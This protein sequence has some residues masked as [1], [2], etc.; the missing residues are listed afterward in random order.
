MKIYFYPS[1]NTKVQRNP[2]VSEFIGNLSNHCTVVNNKDVSGAAIFD[3]CK[4]IFSA[5]IFIYNWIE[6]IGFKR[7]GTLQALFFFCCFFIAKLRRC[8]IVWVFHNITPHEGG[9]HKLSEA[10]RVIMLKHSS[11]IVTHSKD[12]VAYLKRQ[13]SVPVYFSHHPV[14]NTLKL[15]VDIVPFLKQYDILIW[16]RI[17]RYKGIKEFL[18]YLEENN[19]LKTFRIN[20]IGKC[21]DKEYDECL[22]QY[23]NDTINYEN[24]EMPFEELNKL[25]KETRYVLFPYLPDSVSSS[26][27]LID[28][29]VMGG[30][31]LAPNIGAFKDL[32]KENVCLTYTSY[33]NLVEMLSEDKGIEPKERENFI[34]SNKWS[35]FVESLYNIIK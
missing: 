27:A 25:I 8:K 16:G 17:L 7:F 32:N 2:Y 19:L 6:N 3:L 33:E 24:R 23:R 18:Q 35:K 26:G 22:L 30:T 34:N 31:P 28:T 29:I 13:S 9:G 12:A 11:L 10:I 14:S 20:I 5:N 21:V 1:K 15:D 4:Y